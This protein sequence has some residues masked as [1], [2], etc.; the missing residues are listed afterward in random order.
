MRYLSSPRVV[1]LGYLIF[2]F[3]P[4]V[5]NDAHFSRVKDASWVVPAGI[6]LFVVVNALLLIGRYRWLWVLVVLSYVFSDGASLFHPHPDAR[7]VLGLMTDLIAF[8]FLVSPGM[9][10]RLR[11]PVLIA[12]H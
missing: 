10:L 4:L 7:Y 9:R 2:S 12:G 1:I 6:V 11:R 3:I 5:V 8:V